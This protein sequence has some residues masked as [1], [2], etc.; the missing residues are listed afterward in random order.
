MLVKLEVQV[1]YKQIQFF[2]NILMRG[3]PVS[4]KPCY[5]LYFTKDF[6][7][8]ACA[9][10]N[11]DKFHNKFVA[12]SVALSIIYLNFSFY[13]VIIHIEI[14]FNL[15][16]NVISPS[17]LQST[18]SL[19]HLGYL[20]TH[21]YVSSCILRPLS[22]KEPPREIAYNLIIRFS[23]NFTADSVPYLSVQDTFTLK[24]LLLKVA[25]WQVLSR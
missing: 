5:F 4:L 7:V 1:T 16:L 2:F 23:R 20:M 6:L 12:L 11:F 15:S 9:F 21:L 18:A 13:T 14:P 25:S 19:R 17:L 8:T 3:S 22:N 10:K 24:K